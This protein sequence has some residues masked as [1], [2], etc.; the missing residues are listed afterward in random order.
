MFLSLPALVLFSILVPLLLS[1]L[2]KSFTLAE[3]IVLSQGLVITL[4]DVTL[5]VLHLVS[6]CVCVCVCVWRGCTLLSVFFYTQYNLYN[7]PITYTRSTA[8]LYVEVSD[9]LSVC[10]GLSIG[11][12]VCVIPAPSDRGVC[13]LCGSESS[14]L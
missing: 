7:V 2:P 13:V 3:V 10:D 14:P 4:L 6:V 9:C 12:C 11:V 1:L 5:L 8:L